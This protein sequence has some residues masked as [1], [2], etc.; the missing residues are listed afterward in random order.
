[1]SDAHDPYKI[2]ADVMGE[3]VQ[4]NDAETEFDGKRNQENPPNIATT[5]K[6]LRME[7]QGCRKENERM[8]KALEEKNQL[9]VAMLHSLTDPKGR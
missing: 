3:D 5:I 1:M 4:V 6:N 9:T 7:L 8:T 2:E